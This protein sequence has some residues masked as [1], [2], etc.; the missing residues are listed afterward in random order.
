MPHGNTGYVPTWALDANGY[1]AAE[2]WGGWMARQFERAQVRRTEPTAADIERRRRWEAEDA[3]WL[4][5][6]NAVYEAKQR[7]GAA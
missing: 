7:E 1:T 5:R 2:R 6:A 4:A 3:A